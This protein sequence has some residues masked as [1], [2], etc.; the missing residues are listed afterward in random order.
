MSQNYGTITYRVYENEVNLLGVAEVQLPDFESPT[1]PVSGAG[2]PG[3]TEIPVMGQM[4]TLIATFKFQHVNESAARLSTQQVHNV[5]LWIADEYLDHEAGQLEVGARKINMSIIPKKRSNG[6][7]K[8]AS[9]QDVSGEYIVY[10]YSEIIDGKEMTKFDFYN[11]EY[12]DH[13]GINRTEKINKA[14]GI[15]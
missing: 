5:S 6:V 13:S 8:N 7:L 12:T 11:N 9:P 14:L 2:L 1:L 10:K 15:S 3:E 4:K